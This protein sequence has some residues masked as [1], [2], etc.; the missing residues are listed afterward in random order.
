MLQGCPLLSTPSL[1]TFLHCPHGPFSLPHCPSPPSPRTSFAPGLRCPNPHTYILLHTPL[2]P[3]HRAVT[4][5]PWAPTALW[6]CLPMTTVTLFVPMTVFPS[7][8][9]ARP[10]QCLRSCALPIPGLTQLLEVLQ[11]F[12]M[13]VRVPVKVKDPCRHF[14][15]PWSSGR[16]C[17]N[18]SHP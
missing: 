15:L 7:G 16:S 1:N 17:H 14:Y 12:D 6:G 2:L 9:T 3:A 11:R 13:T 10:G 8:P 5:A 4:W 18:H